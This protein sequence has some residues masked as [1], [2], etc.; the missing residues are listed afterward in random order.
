MA[1]LRLSAKLDNIEHFISV[2]FTRCCRWQELSVLF[3][4]GDGFHYYLAQLCENLFFIAS[5]TTSVKKTGAASYKVL[6]FF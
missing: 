1:P 3:V 2:V 6:I 5:M 4:L